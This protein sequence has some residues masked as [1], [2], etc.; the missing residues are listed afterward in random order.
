MAQ[1]SHINIPHRPT[2]MWKALMRR[3]GFAEEGAQDFADALDREIADR[4]TK[5]D[6]KELELRIVRWLFLFAALI[7]AA[8]GVMIRFLA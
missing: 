4:A 3:L 2:I 6:L 7:I 8:I 5:L 1:L